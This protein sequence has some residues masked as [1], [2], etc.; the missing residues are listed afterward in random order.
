MKKL[1]IKIDVKKEEFKKKLDIHD[2]RDGKDGSNG[3]PGKDGNIK[4]LSPQEIRD[5]L[6]LLPKGEKLSIQAIEDL[7]EIIEELRKWRKSIVSPGAGVNVGALSLHF[8]DDET[9]SGTIDG[10]NTVFTTNLTPST[11]TLKVYVNGQRMR[12]VEDYTLSGQTITFLI[13]SPTGSIILC[14]YRT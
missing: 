8:I 14:D 13:A 11:G 1:H 7:A 2:G 3:N 9:P 12:V 10:V 4:D 5:A 6:E